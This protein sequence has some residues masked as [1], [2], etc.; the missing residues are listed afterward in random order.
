MPS[1][2]IVSALIAAATNMRMCAFV[3]TYTQ[4]ECIHLYYLC[5][6]WQWFLIF[7]LPRSNIFCVLTY[8]CVYLCIY[9]YVGS[10]VCMCAG[11]YWCIV[12]QCNPQKTIRLVNRNQ[13][14]LTCRPTWRM[15]AP[16]AEFSKN[17]WLK[18]KCFWLLGKGG[19]RS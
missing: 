2:V 6:A 7:E 19:S 11:I 18:W 17:Y 15:S 13:F 3:C 16:I 4:F 5:I 14:M 1:H 12:Q 9:R 10:Y 8:V